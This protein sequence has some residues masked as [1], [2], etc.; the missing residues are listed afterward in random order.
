MKLDQSCLRPTKATMQPFTPAALCFLCSGLVVIETQLTQDQISV[1]RRAGKSASISCGGI[2]EC[3]SYVL[4]YQKKESGTFERLLNIAKSG[5]KPT[6]YSHAE[7]D[8]FSARIQQNNCELIIFSVKPSHAASYYCSCWKSGT[9]VREDVRHLNKNQLLWINIL[10]DGNLMSGTRK[11]ERPDVRVTCTETGIFRIR[12]STQMFSS[13]FCPSLFH[14][15]RIF[16]SGTRLVVSDAALVQPVLSV[17]PAASRDPL[18]GRTALLCVASDMVPPLVRF[19]WRRQR[20][21]SA[22]EESPPAHEEELQLREPGRITSIRLLDRDAVHTYKY[23]CSVQ[24]E[25]GA[26]KA[27][28]QQEVA[29][30]P[31]SIPP[32][33]PPSIP[34]SIPPSVPPS[35]PP[36]IPPSVLRMKLL[37][38]VY[39]A[40]MMKSLLSCC[41][42][43]L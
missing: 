29:P 24:H 8:D 34:P 2:N 22:V 38:F 20:A 40:L 17:Y 28:S 6:R 37:S 41:G 15:V 21:D 31:P 39:T 43:S 5:G 10:S 16:G 7:K 30:V 33:A 3:G 23:R 13:R 11:P 14:C 19:S 12:T 18:E 26:V 36:S 1:T 42:I 4:W 35:I 25:G 32:S 27:Q 9:T